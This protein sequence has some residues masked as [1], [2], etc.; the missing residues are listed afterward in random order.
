MVWSMTDRLKN[1]LRAWRVEAGWT[2]EEV[3]DLVGYSVSQLSRAERGERNLSPEA[4]V[5]ISRRLG[6]PVRELFEVE[7][8]EEA[9]AGAA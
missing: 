7:S 8:E 6:V 2:L 4:K 5:R 3:A 1:R 9:P